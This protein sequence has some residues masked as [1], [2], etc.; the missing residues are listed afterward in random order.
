M[1]C[2]RFALHLQ[3]LVVHLGRV[4]HLVKMVHL[5]GPAEG[6]IGRASVVR[7]GGGWGWM[8]SKQGAAHGKSGEVHLVLSTCH[9]ISGQGLADHS[10][11]ISGCHA[12]SGSLLQKAD[13]AC[14]EK[15]IQTPMA[16]G[17][18]TKIISMTE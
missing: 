6:G 10:H 1:G 18:S 8:A 7:Q 3:S 12:I 16:P 9:A 4:V 14:L 2:D 17:R 13:T 15:E 11:A 5:C